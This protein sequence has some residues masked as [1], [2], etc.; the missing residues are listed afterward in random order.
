MV[1][2]IEPRT[3]EVIEVERILG[4]RFDVTASLTDPVGAGTVTAFCGTCHTTTVP[5]GTPAGHWIFNGRGLGTLIPR[6]EQR[7]PNPV[8][9]VTNP[10]NNQTTKGLRNN[11][12]PYRASGG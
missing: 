10:T 7:N 5:S 1:A 12:A 2:L 4:S 8:S 9:N 11:L 3:N 6:F